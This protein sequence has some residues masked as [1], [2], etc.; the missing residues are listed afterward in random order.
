MLTEL[1]KLELY[2][3]RLA[4]WRKA[5][6]ENDP[7]TAGDTEPIPKAFGITLEST[8]HVAE[9]IREQVLKT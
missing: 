7:W 9:K 1:D 4:R 2:H 5:K 8:L 3:A 6:L